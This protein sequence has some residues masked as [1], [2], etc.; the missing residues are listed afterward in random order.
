[1]MK[2]KKILIRIGSLRHGGAEK[3]LINFLKNIPPNK[4]EIDLLLN[5]YS[6]LYIKDVPSWINL[7]YLI[8]GEMITTNRP[9]DIPIKAFRVLYE[10]MFLWFPF[11]LYRFI[12]KN[13][14]Y[15]V[16]I[17]G[18][19]GLY[20]EILSSPQKNSKKIIWVHNDVFS[21][22]GYTPK[23]IRKFFRF[24]R[25]LVISNKILDGMYDLAQ[26][27]DEKT[28]VIK[29]FNPIDRNETLRKADVEIY[30]FPFTENLP[31]FISIGTIFPQK[32]YDRLLNVH[33]RLI[34]EGLK[35]QLLIIGDGYDFN[36]IQDQLNR[37]GIKETAKMFGFTGNPYPYLKKA[38]FYVS[39][40]RHEGF[41]TVIA[42][43]LIF[44]K[45]ISATDVSGIRDLL[46]D[47]MLGNITKNS[48]EGIYEGM[49][50][51]LTEKSVT[52]AYRKRIKESELPFTL[53]KSVAHLQKIIDEV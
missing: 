4:Y 17:A 40:S 12:L 8:K 50:M 21:I 49:K 33:K 19:H 22:R 39:S 26:N 2:K 36:T 13:K 6:G 51:F 34:D 25:I 44:Q 52:E 46:Q 42:E 38:D 14:K 15:D 43:A 18:I 9:K 41:P 11:L 30:N 31:T 29:I 35:H 53:E 3:V 48:E 16:E 28:A 23:I 24:N 47:G 37:L 20:K 5:L 45:P 27:E 10:K 7:H 1:M 32:G